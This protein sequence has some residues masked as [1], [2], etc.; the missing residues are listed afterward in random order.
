M[1][2]KL[3]LLIGLFA[4]AFAGCV[5][6]EE[7]VLPETGDAPVK[8]NE[9]YSN[10]GRSTY[11]DLD[12]IELYNNSDAAFNVG[13]YVL[14]D[15]IDKS[16]KVII[17]T[18]TTIAARGFLVV[19]VDVDGGFG[20]SSSGDMVHLEDT[21]GR[22]IDKIEFGAQTPEQAAARVPDGSDNIILQTPTRGASNNGVVATPSVTGLA[23]APVSPTSDEDVTVT[24]TVTAGEGTLTSVK[25]Q[26]TLN[27]ATQPDIAMTNTAASYSATIPKQAAGSEIAYSVV[28]INS[29]GG[30]S[31]VPGTPYTV[32]NASST[33]YSGLVIN[34]V[35]GNGKFIEIYNKGTA[36]IPL[37]GVTLVKNESATWWT[38]GAATVGAGEYHVISNGVQ[39]GITAD[40]TTGASGI[41]PKQNV[42]FQLKD[43]SGN[44]LDAFLR[45][46]GGNLSDGVTPDYGSGT[47]YSFSRCPDGV[48]AFG[49]AVPSSK[50]ANPFTP[51]GAIATNDSPVN[52][53]DLVINEVDGNG[54]FIE[55]YN[56]GAA[57]ISLE[58]V[59]LYKNLSSL[60]W[61][62]GSTAT[63]AAGGY[64]TIV[65]SG[66]SVAGAS[67]YTGASGI[68]PKKTVRFDLI[69]PGASMSIDV[70]ARV[71]ADN[72][73]DANCTPDYSSGTKY[74]FSRCPDGTGTF[75]LA[76]PSCNAA[77][78][79]TAAGDIVTN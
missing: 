44:E 7:P 47:K 55:I 24:A 74:S 39:S 33:D 57:A 35:D 48:G 11:G 17:P 10:G 71:K 6:D 52:Y 16:E 73:L 61:T 42:Q 68:S 19:E 67:E 59:K 14:Y 54:K 25:I 66:G 12:W 5:K 18:N 3:T 45:S 37:A 75:G 65:E 79:A 28:A 40:E 64:Y 8:I 32:R 13:G 51:A 76:V 22:L 30:S 69:A 38:G 2:K 36:A 53:A 15:K 50:A 29:A 21:E 70:F 26:W 23:H 31:T 27:T 58:N 72:V 60:W 62:G 63:I 20:L 43:P 78:P 4:A 1:K 34:E 49:L 46:N 56:K 41:S 9:A 77:N